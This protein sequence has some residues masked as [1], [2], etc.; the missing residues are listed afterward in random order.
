MTT[1]VFT[2]GF[3]RNKFSDLIVY[4]GHQDITTLR[5]V[6]EKYIRP[7][8]VWGSGIENSLGNPLPASQCQD[9]GPPHLGH[10]HSR[11]WFI[12]FLDDCTYC[13][14]HGGSL[15]L[16]PLPSPHSPRPASP[17][18]RHRINTV[19]ESGGDSINVLL[20]V[21]SWKTC[22]PAWNVSFMKPIYRAGMQSIG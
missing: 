5:N 17:P 18:V 12:W 16:S 1:F 6:Y 21:K 11:S 3:H 10:G 2:G 22:M 19:F 14:K 15:A 4:V 13:P 7:E 8:E 20:R 9:L